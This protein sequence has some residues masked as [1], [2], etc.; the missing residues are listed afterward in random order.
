MAVSITLSFNYPWHELDEDE[1]DIQEAL[2]E[3]NPEEL[4]C[5]AKNA[6]EP[7]SVSIEVY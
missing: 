6:G 3:L 4:L 1:N 7:I 5:A 2:E